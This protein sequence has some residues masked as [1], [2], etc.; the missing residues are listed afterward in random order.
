MATCPLCE[1]DMDEA[2][3]CTKNMVLYPV[4][5]VDGGG[6][7]SYAVPFGEENRVSSD[8]KV[9]ASRDRCPDC[10]V[11]EGG[12]HHPGCDVEESPLTGE[13]LLMEVL[14]SP[15]G[16]QPI[17]GRGQHD[18]NADLTLGAVHEN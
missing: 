6:H 5:G 1:R 4:P 9:E 2:A 15:D 13:Q 3:S 17:H 12:Y 11:E 8:E 10:G 14:G 7:W 16:L 18:P